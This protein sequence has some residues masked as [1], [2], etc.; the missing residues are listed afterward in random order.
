MRW[1][2]KNT[3]ETDAAGARMERGKRWSED[4]SLHGWLQEFSAIFTFSHSSKAH[5]EIF[6]KIMT[7]EWYIFRPDLGRWLE[8]GFMDRFSN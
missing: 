5:L 7:D 3:R 2:H 4:E 6:G 1:N 8:E